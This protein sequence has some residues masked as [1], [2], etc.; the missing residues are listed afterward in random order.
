MGSSWEASDSAFGADEPGDVGVIACSESSVTRPWCAGETKLAGSDA[1]RSLGDPARVGSRSSAGADA[2]ADAANSGSA[3][4]S[5]NGIAG[6][7]GVRGDAGNA[8]DRIGGGRNASVP[9]GLAGSDRARRGSR[10][11]NR[12]LRFINGALWGRVG[13]GVVG[14]AV[15]VES[16]VSIRRAGFGGSDGLKSGMA[17]VLNGFAFVARW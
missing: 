16:D 7:T 4:F 17:Q 10:A 3:W 2:D 1:R 14:P 12:G 5:A 15:G 13:V 6:N 11:S 8:C 9:R